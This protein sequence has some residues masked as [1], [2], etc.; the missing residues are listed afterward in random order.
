[1]KKSTDGGQTW[2]KLQIVYGESTPS[3]LVTIGNP[4]PIALHTVPGKVVLIACRNNAEVLQLESQDFGASWTNATYIT[5]QA[6]RANWTWIATGPPT[7]LQLTS[8]RLLIPADHMSPG[9]GSHAMLSDDGGKT[10]TLSNSMTG[11][12]GNECQAARCANGSLIMNQ[13]TQAGIRQFSWSDDDGTTVSR[14]DSDA[15]FQLLFPNDAK[16]IVVI[17]RVGLF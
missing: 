13:R 12:G 8:G 14:R 2:G 9:W 11:L 5:S 10:W 15:F 6:K 7:G 3:H 16:L 17:A 4:S 1:M